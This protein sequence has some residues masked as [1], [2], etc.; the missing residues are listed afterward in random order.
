MT[1]AEKEHRDIRVYGR[2]QGVGFR[3]YTRKCALDTGITGYVSNEND[4][5]V[6]IEAEGA[7]GRLDIFVEM[8]RRGPARAIVTDVRIIPG[9][10]VNYLNF[11]IR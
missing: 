3:Y 5:S 2:V 4:G 11:R 6:F 1:S 10:P 7:P 9:P 8:C